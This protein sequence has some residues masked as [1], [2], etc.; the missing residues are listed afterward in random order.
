MKKIIIGLLIIL[1]SINVLASDING[2]VNDDGIIGT[3]DYVLIRKHLLNISLLTGNILK[4]A[5]VN[6]DGKI[7]IIDYILIRKM[8][9]GETKIKLS[10]PNDNNAYYNNSKF[11]KNN[12]ESPFVSADP[13]IYYENGVYYLFATFGSGGI[14][15]YSSSDLIDWSDNGYVIDKKN[16]NNGSQKSFNAFWA[17]ELFK[18]NNK[19]YLIYSGGTTSNWNIQL[20][21][22]VSDKISSGWQYY[23]M[24]PLNKYA[25][26]NIDGTVLI[27]NGN[28][29]LYYHAGND[30]YAVQLSKDLKSIIG[31]PQTIL[32]AKQSWAT[33]SKPPL[34]EGPS[35]FKYNGKYYLMYSAN[36]YYT[37]WY[38]VGYATSSSPLGPF[39]DQ[40]LN[41]PLL[42]SNDGPGHNSLFTIDGKNYYIVYHSII[43]KNGAFVERKLNIDQFGVDNSGK[44]FINGPTNINLPLPSGHK[45]KYQ[46]NRNEYDVIVSAKNT[47]ELKDGINYNAL[48]TSKYLNINPITACQIITTKSV[49]INLNNKTVE[50]IWLYS[51]GTNFNNTLATVTINNKYIL[52][53]IKINGVK[54]FKLQLPLLKDKINKI[55]LDFSN[56]ISLSEISLYT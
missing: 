40:T 24:I 42:T 45:G 56:N 55:Q 31:S 33:H 29:Y 34:N 3:S 16:F 32:Y 41:T 2:D 35:I 1:V 50:D 8:I 54:A 37:K 10:I 20:Y 11:I 4:Q 5:D 12:K 26:L 43:W 13:M 21:L 14:K 30:L 18:Y 19:Y 51:D 39:T 7:T 48:S 46:L 6:S 17:P 52:E 38:G 28:V 27:E 53:N 44:L 47:F 25:K 49:T 36:D 23:S 9:L 22:A 15:Y